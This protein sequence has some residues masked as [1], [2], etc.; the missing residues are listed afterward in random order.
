[1]SDQPLRRDE[2]QLTRA[3]T[4]HVGVC[5]GCAGHPD[6]DGAEWAATP[7]QAIANAQSEA[8]W[9]SMPD[10]RLLCENCWTAEDPELADD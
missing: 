10:G 5:S 4:F 7:E 1:M 2:R 6:C 3:V 8:E 9:K